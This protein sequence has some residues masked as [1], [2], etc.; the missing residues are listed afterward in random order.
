MAWV[1]VGFYAGLPYIAGFFGI[2]FAGWWSDWLLR[3]TG[4]LNV[5]RK[6][7]V[8]VGLVGAATIVCANFVDSTAAVVAIL[9]VAFFAQAMS[10]SGWSVLSEMAPTGQLGL[11]GGLF[12]AA[13]NL[14]GIVTPILIGW[15]IA[16]TGSYVGAL[17]MV[18]AIAAVGACAWTFLLGDIRPIGVEG[19]L[20]SSR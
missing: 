3:R 9:S 11:L 5:A 12:S 6:V 14:S 4:S 16:R 8:I 20:V 13:A 17:Y 1:Q 19:Q 7:P 10:S 15:I 18:G 2:L